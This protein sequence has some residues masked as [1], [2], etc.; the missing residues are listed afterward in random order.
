MPLIQK[1]N[2]FACNWF[3]MHCGIYKFWFIC[4]KLIT[5]IE[6]QYYVNLK[7]N[8]NL[9]KFENLS[10]QFEKQSIISIRSFFSVMDWK[11]PNNHFKALNVSSMSKFDF[12]CWFLRLTFASQMLIY[13]CQ[14]GSQLKYPVNFISC[15][16]Y[17]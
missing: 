11:Q 9:N 13:E 16:K 17:T 8:F 3:H 10:I 14:S 15:N 7:A 12:F 4:R 6:L 1:I 2:I 5:T